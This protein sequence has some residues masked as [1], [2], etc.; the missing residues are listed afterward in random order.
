MRARGR[1]TSIHSSG[2]YRAVWR[3]AWGESVGSYCSIVKLDSSNINSLLLQ[4]LPIEY[5][6]HNSRRKEQPFTSMQ[7]GRRCRH[8]RGR[9]HHRL[10]RRPFPALP[11]GSPSRA[12]HSQP[13]FARRPTRQALV[14][15]LADALAPLF[16]ERPFAL[17]G[18]SMG[19]WVAAALALEL[20]ARGGPLP[21]KLYASGNR[22]PML[23]G[24]GQPRGGW[25]AA[26]LEGGGCGE[27]RHAEFR[28][29]AC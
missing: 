7:V 17:L 28:E 22:S 21:L 26:G 11:A 4:L 25:R 18:H 15:A 24:E 29:G 13:A 9:G 20:Q 8:C 6:G 10:P 16:R 14:A 3:W 12:A 27:T 1:T 5:P 2:S 19:A 23:A